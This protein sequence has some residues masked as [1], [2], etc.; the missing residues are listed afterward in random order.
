MTPKAGAPR[1]LTAN[2]RQLEW[3]TCDLETFVPEDHRAR[4]LWTLVENLDLTRFYDCVGARGGDAGRPATDPKILL[5]LWLYATS[6]GIG[7]A[8]ELDRLCKSHDVYRWICG[9]VSVNY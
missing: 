3:R 2:R 6:E 7:S 5:A 4:A 1:V 9:G 8:R